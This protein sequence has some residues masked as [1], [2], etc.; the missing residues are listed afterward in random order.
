MGSAIAPGATPMMGQ[1][2]ALKAEAGDALLL[3]RMGDFYE[4][5]F[6]DAREVARLLDIALTARG[7]HEGRPVPMCGIPVHA[8]EA[9]L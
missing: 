7:E 5:F 1:V 2:L 4:A 3:V 9:Y 8:Q 6:D